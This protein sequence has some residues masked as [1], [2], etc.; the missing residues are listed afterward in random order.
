[1]IFHPQV[2]HSMSVSL[3][4]SMYFSFLFKYFIH[5]Y[6]GGRE[7][8]REHERGGGRSRGRRRLPRS[9]EPIAGLDEIMTEPKQM[10]NRL[11]NPGAP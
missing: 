10:L 5:L 1:M 7:S 4:L 9:R 2:P 11:N 8:E 6:E 3:L